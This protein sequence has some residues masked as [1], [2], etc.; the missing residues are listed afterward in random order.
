M[1][2]PF[3]KL[4]NDIPS[5]IT[6]HQTQGLSHM[7]STSLQFS[8]TLTLSCSLKC[9]GYS[10][11]RDLCLFC[12]PHFCLCHSCPHGLFS[13][14]ISSLLKFHLPGVASPDP[15]AFLQPLTLLPNIYHQLHE[16]SMRVSYFSISKTR[17]ASK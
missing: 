15:V 10:H 2:F 12:P 3:W 4:F 14:I 5:Q 9:R 16:S 7:I 13:H 8:A 11:L 1:T 17:L 6:T